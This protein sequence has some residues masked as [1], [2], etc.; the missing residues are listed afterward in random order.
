MEVGRANHRQ[1]T[2]DHKIQEI[3]MDNKSNKNKNKG[4]EELEI[5]I[6]MQNESVLR[7]GENL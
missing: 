2:D 1:E 7:D 4:K 6:A 3:S 5:A